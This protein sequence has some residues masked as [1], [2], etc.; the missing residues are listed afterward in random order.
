MC[1][2]RR[3]RNHATTVSC[4]WQLQR[5][6]VIRLCG[7]VGGLLCGALYFCAAVKRPNEWPPFQLSTGRRRRRRRRIFCSQGAQSNRCA[8][9]SR[10]LQSPH[11]E[12]AAAEAHTHTHMR[13]DGVEHS[14]I[15]VAKLR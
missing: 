6:S 5:L 3:L 10:P 7:S 11:S 8:N 15:V 13:R 9:G 1:V 2:R 4:L 12:R 14:Q